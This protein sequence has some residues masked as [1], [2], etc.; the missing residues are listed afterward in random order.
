MKGGFFLV[1][2]SRKNRST[3]D[4]GQKPRNAR[5]K[6]FVSY[7]LSIILISLVAISGLITL[8]ILDPFVVREA[9]QTA[10]DLLQRA[11]PRTYIDA[12][13]KIVDID[14]PSLEKLGQWPWP[15]DQLAELVDR[16]HAAGAAVVAFDF[17][18]VEPD[19]MTSSGLRPEVPGP[20]LRSSEG[21]NVTISELSNDE[22]FADALRRGNVVLGFGSSPQV[23][24][25]PPVKAGFAFTGD[26]PAPYI[27]K[28]PGGA[29]LLPVLA[30]AAAGVG[31][32]N[33]R[34]DNSA[35][36]VRVVQLLWSDGEDLYPSLITESLR[37][38]QGAQTYV[39]HADEGAGRVQSLRIGAFDVPTGPRGEVILY[40]TKYRPDR[41]VSAADIFD[42][43]RLTAL[44]PDLS[45]KIVLIGTSATGLFDLHRT[46]LGQTVPGV[47]MHAQAM[48]QIIQQQFLVRKDW[49]RTAELLAML[50]ACLA[51]SLATIFGT[52]QTA[53]L[54]GA[55]ISAVISFGIWYAFRDL[56]VLVDFS[57]PL[58]SGLAV[59]FI[60][61]VFRYI[62][63]D[64]EKRGIRTA[65]SRYVHPEVLKDIE[66]NYSQ[67]QLGGEN[68]ELT[69][70][71]TDVR[72]FTPLSERL[73]PEEVVSFLNRLLSRLGAE[74]AE[75]AGVIDKFIG[76][77]VMAFWNAP[78]RQP[79]HCRRAC[80]AALKMRSAVQGMNA[81]Q[82]FGLPEHVA[83]DGPIEIGVGI[84]T[85]PACVGNVGSAER[86]NY[87]AI[88][89]AVNVAARVE[90]ACKEV[91]YDLVV[92]RSTAEQVP[93]FAFLEA[94]GVALKGKTDRVSLM[95]LV[96]DETVSASADF[97]ELREKH[98][99]LI[100]ALGRNDPPSIERALEDCRPLARRFGPKLVEFI[101]KMP[102]RMEDF[103]APEAVELE[104][105]PAG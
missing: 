17:L 23:T 99:R 100:E 45:G 51:V 24:G 49:T 44:V 52:A 56:G 89:D 65:F 20:V 66:R 16:L 96:G 31:S 101:N 2:R 6:R 40:Y 25:A 74:I 71:F 36:A 87:S 104:L 59:W 15:R 70:M 57:F 67:V 64:R 39:V 22:I 43:E 54:V 78:L 12:P 26:D 55:A 30:E 75:E 14:E 90:S 19:R 77:A 27:T 42:N 81:D 73:A 92:C 48:E 93:D 8:R 86:F 53:L 84:N 34:A 33:L 85:G 94:G 102:T 1:L 35:Q 7:H 58:G 82:S 21:G 79:D 60:V 103:A 63:T 32:V 38:A 88:G 9:R 68:C 97:A 83:R 4:G 11:E 62:V 69:V 91:G 76:D 3:E 29:R 41:Y 61:T 13:I 105:V 18:F 46:A 28:L 37:I 10:F 5:W 98:A 47:E 72:N 95:V 80:A 50:I